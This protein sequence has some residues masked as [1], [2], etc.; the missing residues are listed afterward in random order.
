MLWTKSMLPTT[1]KEVTLE[2]CVVIHV[3]NGKVTEEWEYS[4]DL[5]LL[6]QLGIVPPLG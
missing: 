3:T 6:Q 4:D 1:G 5:G 2:G